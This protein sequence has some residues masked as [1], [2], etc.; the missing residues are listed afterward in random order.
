M[1]TALRARL[2]PRRVVHAHCDIPCGIYDPH[3]A[4]LAAQTVETMVT[5]LQALPNDNSE[6]ARN[7]FT[8]MVAVKEAHAERVK[9]EVLIIWGDY[10]KP[11]HL[12]AAPDLH[13]MVWK[14]V[15]LASAC[16]QSI[17]AG[18]AAELRRA[19]DEFARVFAATKK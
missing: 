13:D 2:S 16:K 19:V 7:S 10:M 4:Q 17:D 9:R 1:L 12:A 3:E 15:K 14:T 18:T 11:E 6:S 5:K 8:R